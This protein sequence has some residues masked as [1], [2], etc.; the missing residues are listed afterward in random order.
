MKYWTTV[1]HWCLQDDRF[2]LE[3]KGLIKYSIKNVLTFSINHSELLWMWNN[4]GFVVM[5]HPDT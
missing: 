4:F 2:K 3:L 1:S 5:I